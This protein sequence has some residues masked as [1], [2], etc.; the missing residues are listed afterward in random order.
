VGEGRCRSDGVD[1]MK[2][3]FKA[4]LDIPLRWVVE[5]TCAWPGN[6][7]RL[8]KDFAFLAEY[9]ARM[10]YI[11]AIHRMMRRLTPAD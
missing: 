3:T 11:A 10:I 7:R 2:A 8:S 5:R 4:M 9:R 6:F 1:W